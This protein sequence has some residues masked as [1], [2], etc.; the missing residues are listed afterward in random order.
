MRT[1]VIGDIHGCAK[2]LQRLLIRLRA[3]EDRDRLILLGDLFDRGPDSWEVLQQVI[4]LREAFQE[5]FCLLLGNH[6]DYLLRDKL[7]LAQRLVWERVGRQATVRSFKRHGEDMEECV[8][9]LKAHC[10]LFYRGE[11][12]QCAH[13][14]VKVDPLEAND[15]A[16]LVHDHSI[17]HANVYRGPLTVTGH[18]ALDGPKWFAGD[19]KTEEYLSYD[20]W[21]PLPDTG[22]LCIDTGC[23]KGGWLTGMMIEERDGRR[24]YCLKKAEEK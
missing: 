11:D 1:Y 16:T 23:G 20:E 4:E 14:G 9:W 21:R 5:R 22:I 15:Q 17:V 10:Q 7:T 3:D 6:E 2:A 13:A 18:I 12:V 19:G 8:P 24:L